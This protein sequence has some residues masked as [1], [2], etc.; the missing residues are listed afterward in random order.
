[1]KKTAFVFP[2][3]GSQSVGMGQEWAGASTAA[4]RVFEEA[5]EALGFSLSRLC[6]EGPAEDLQL[7]E[8][9]QPAILTTSIA[10]LRVLEEAGLRP[11]IVAGHSL[12]EYSAH[13]AAG[14]LELSDAV[15]LVR[16]RGR[17][18]QAA[19]P[20]GVGAMAAV[21]GLDAVAVGEVARQAAQG[22]VCAVANYN[23]PE[24]SVLAGH[25]TAIERALVLAKEAGAKRALP[26]PVSAPFHCSL[27]SP[28][29][30]ALEPLLAET[31]FR[32]PAVPVIANVEAAAVTTGE[33]AREALAQQVDGAV[34]WVE[35][36]ET[37]VDD[38]GVGQFVEVG[39]G[40]VLSGLARR[41][42]KEATHAP[43]SKPEAVAEL[44]EKLEA[45]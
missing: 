36:V 38:H 26:L 7:T 32:D 14:T 31:N 9:T 13:V 27:M 20:I 28:A 25:A 6:W 17:F 10:M 24:Q 43:L 33:A 4:R 1:M 11:D 44:V 22:E 16:E 40:K 37:M 23:S 12:G 41:I 8:N 29:R 15:R 19:V 35:C 30:E 45:S 21:I 2:G 18:M 42:R 39:P 3:Q 34:R 5:D